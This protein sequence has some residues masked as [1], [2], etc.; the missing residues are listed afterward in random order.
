MIWQLF[1]QQ[2]K[3]QP[4]S[5]FN[6]SFP[7]FW[8]KKPTKKQCRHLALCSWSFPF[9]LL[10]VFFF[11]FNRGD[12]TP[13]I[14]NAIFPQPQTNT[15]HSH[16]YIMHAPSYSKFFTFLSPHPNSSKPIFSSRIKP[17]NDHPPSQNNLPQ[18]LQ[19]TL[20]PPSLPIESTSIF[21]LFPNFCFTF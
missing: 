11:S 14:P 3:K 19:Q 21:L 17:K 7:R 9:F 16:H 10:S 4:L 18:I 12:Y 8:K 1:S 6:L 15:T 5:P 2:Q 20:N 13:I